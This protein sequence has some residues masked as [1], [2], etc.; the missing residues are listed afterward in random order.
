VPDDPVTIKLLFNQLARR[1]R[2][3]GFGLLDGETDFDGDL[4]VFNLVLLDAPA[5]FENLELT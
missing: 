3:H 1:Q 4:P 5:G 2:R